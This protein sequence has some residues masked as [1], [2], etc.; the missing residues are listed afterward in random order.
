M[1]KVPRESPEFRKAH[2]DALDAIGKEKFKDALVHLKRLIELDG[3]NGDFPRRASDCHF[4]LGNPPERLDF[5]LLAARTYAQA[6]L[7]LKAIAM[8]KVALSINSRHSE[9]LSL[10]TQLHER[11]QPPQAAAPAQRI[12][13]ATALGRVKLARRVRPVE[14]PSKEE[15]TRASA[16]E[17]RARQTAAHAL[18]AIRARRAQSAEHRAVRDS[19]ETLS[20]V[21]PSNPVTL[22]AIEL[23]QRIPVEAQ[24]KSIPPARG[25]SY[26]F[27]LDELPSPER[28]TGLPEFVSYEELEPPSFARHAFEATPLLS[29]LRPKLLVRLIAG[30]E[31]VELD[32]GQVLFREGDIADAMYVVADGLVHATTGNL[33]SDAH[34]LELARLSEGEFFG[35]IGLL[36]DQPRQASVSALEPTRLLRFTRA[37]V[38]ELTRESDEFLSTLLQF[39]QDRL[40]ADL[41]LTSP[42]FAP[43][44][45]EAKA[46]IHSEFEFLEVEPDVLLLDY[47]EK[48]TGL[49][50]ILTGSALCASSPPQ[51][52]LRRLE[53]GDIFGERALLQD[54]PAAVQ[55]RTMGKC[56]ALN[57][58]AQIFRALLMEYPTIL[59]FVTQ[60]DSAWSEEIPEDWNEHHTLF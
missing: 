52:R 53:P 51:A 58:P 45:E 16:Q 15:T 33:G 56:F 1:T 4:R 25:C 5:A 50:V 59:E 60:T 18:R 42:L 30:L 32:P 34:D 40:V 39:L 35:E 13:G 47:G 11:A 37:A 21:P 26:S 12:S 46:R 3:E 54:R 29:H 41:M 19:E 17:T 38:A 22:E 55:V 20:L 44:S 2:E 7:L 23:S 10:L 27:T 24:R 8:C 49:Y 43:L 57:L 36:S 28:I 6:G 48:P 9:A 14:P 31:L